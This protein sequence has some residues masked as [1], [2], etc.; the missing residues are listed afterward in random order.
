MKSI[1][2]IAEEELIYG[3]KFGMALTLKTFLPVQ[4]NGAAIILVLSEGWYSNL[5]MI[6]QVRTILIEP[7][8]EAGYCLFVIVHSSNPRFSIPDAI[9]DIHRS[10]RFVRYNSQNY[11]IDPNRIGVLGGSAAG[12]LGLSVACNQSNQD[13]QGDDIG[14]VSSDIAAAAIFFPLV[15]FLNWGEVG[16]I[17]LGDHPVVPLFGAFDF[18]E[19]DPEKQRFERVENT[20]KHLS[21]AKSL[22]PL[23]WVSSKQAPTYLVVGDADPVVPPEQSYR[24]ADKMKVNGVAHKLQII[25]DG[26]HDMNMI[27]Q[28]LEGAINWFDTYLLP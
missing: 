10:V 15:D 22:S 1:Q 2:A 4:K 3:R 11:G 17:M 23:E 7:I 12:H 14:A 26:G 20:D 25:S 9:D 27:A 21:I 8:V 28:N 5:E 13:F 18:D 24:L 19:I 6:E 16:K